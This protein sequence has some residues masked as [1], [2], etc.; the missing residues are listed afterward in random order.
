M[1]EKLNFAKSSPSQKVKPLATG[2][3]RAVPD[4]KSESGEEREC[5]FWRCKE[6]ASAGRWSLVA[7]G[8]AWARACHCP[9]PPA[10]G[11]LTTS[12]LSERAGLQGSLTRCLSPENLLDCQQLVGLRLSF[13]IGRVWNGPKEA[14]C[15]G[16]MESLEKEYR[17]KI[18]EK[19]NK[20][21]WLVNFTS[22]SRWLYSRGV[23][24]I[25]F[26][27]WDEWMAKSRCSCSR[28]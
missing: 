28:F 22:K 3:Y 20:A 9:P 13:D 8:E 7:P 2:R 15:S 21:W 19:W 18:P 4:T 16:M 24:Q 26:K 17:L 1:S 10:R 5:G 6:G 14:K 11:K 27:V 25:N 23:K 12:I